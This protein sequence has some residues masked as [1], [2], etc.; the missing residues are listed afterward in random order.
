MV[1]NNLNTAWDR[2]QNIIDSSYAKEKEAINCFI[3]SLDKPLPQQHLFHG[4]HDHLLKITRHLK[5]SCDENIKQIWLQFLECLETSSVIFPDGKRVKI[6]CLGE[7]EILAGSEDGTLKI[8]LLDVNRANLS[9]DLAEIESITNQSFVKAPQKRQMLLNQ[10][11]VILARNT[12][13]QRIE[14][15]MWLQVESEGARLHLRRIAR[16]PDACAKGVGTN[17]LNHLKQN[18]LTLY[19][20]SYLDVRASNQA[21]ELYQKYGFQVVETIPKN[22]SY[23]VDD[24]YIMAVCPKKSP[25]LDEETQEGTEFF[26]I[27]HENGIE[28]DLDV[29]KHTYQNVSLPSISNQIGSVFNNVKGE[30]LN[31]WARYQSN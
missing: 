20:V 23:P 6:E 1:V 13:N 12:L 17:L 10:N 26:L 18:Y 4:F 21:K 2:A 3:Q 8:E 19:P 15:Y 25:S 16:R 22:F 29:I 30:F 14:G 9:Q 11:I 5:G 7:R 28:T 24:K 27:N 31:F